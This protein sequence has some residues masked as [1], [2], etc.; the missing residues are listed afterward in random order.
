M[1]NVERYELAVP[2]RNS[3][4]VKPPVEA[5][6]SRHSKLFRAGK[7]IA[8]KGFERAQE[9][10]SAS[11]DVVVALIHGEFAV[12]GSTMND[13][14]VMV[15]PSTRTCPAST[16]RCCFGPRFYQVP[17]PRASCQV[18]Q[19]ESRID[20][21]LVD[22]PLPSAHHPPKWWLGME[23]PSS[24]SRHLPLAGRTNHLASCGCYQARVVRIPARCDRSQACGRCLVHRYPQV[25]GIA[26]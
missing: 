13:G 6:I 12:P 22:R 5:P 26:R 11:V 16:S 21:L 18:G 20:M 3:T 23:P 4:S 2:L 8:G 14:L 10:V 1:P 9:F 25:R 24:T 7:A 15:S 19:V 17:K